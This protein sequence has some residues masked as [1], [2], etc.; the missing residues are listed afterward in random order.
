MM[1]C[2]NICSKEFIATQYDHNVQAVPFSDRCRGRGV[3]TQ[4]PQLRG[5]F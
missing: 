3:S 5:L 2:L 4:M 1:G